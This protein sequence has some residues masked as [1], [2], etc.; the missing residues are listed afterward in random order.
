[1]SLGRG[2]L[3]GAVLGLATA[4]AVVLTGPTA[5]AK[6]SYDSPYGFERTWNAG[7]RMIRV[8][9][10]FKVVEKDDAT[11]YLLFDY[12]S[13]ETGNKPKAGSMEFIRGHESDASVRVV[14]QLPEMPRYHEQVLIDELT[15]KLKREYGEPPAPRKRSEP[16]RDAG[17]DAATSAEP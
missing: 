3:V 2:P 10:G 16:S 6:S 4:V 5:T 7:L 13:P 1:M 8:D 9:M 17:S 15:R 14:V 12:R 11:G